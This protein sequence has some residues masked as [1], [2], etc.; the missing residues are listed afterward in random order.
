MEYLDDGDSQG[1]I[2]SDGHD[3]AVR[4]RIIGSMEKIAGNKILCKILSIP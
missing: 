2:I 4:K 1:K 3:A